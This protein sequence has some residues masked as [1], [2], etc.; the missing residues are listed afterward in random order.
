MKP[1]LQL[2]AALMLP[3]LEQVDYTVHK[4]FVLGEVRN[5]EFRPDVNN[6]LNQSNFLNQT[7]FANPSA[8]LSNALPGTAASVGNF[9]QSGQAYTSVT[10]GSAFGMANATVS[11]DVGLGSQRQVQ[12]SL[13]LNF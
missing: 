7:N 4:K 1:L 9:L 12:M 3:G 6:I 13:R 5:L 2:L 10:S 11:R 8:V